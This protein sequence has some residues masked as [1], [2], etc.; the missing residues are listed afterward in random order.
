MKQT[1]IVGFNETT[2]I[3]MS[4]GILLKSFFDDCFISSGLWPPRSLDLS[5][6][7]YDYFLRGYLKNQEYSP[8]PATFEDL[9]RNIVHEI[10]RVPFSMMQRVIN[11][12][13]K[14]AQ[15]CIQGV[16]GQ[17]EHL[18]QYFLQYIFT[19]VLLFF[20]LNFL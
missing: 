16:G 10:D 8:A 20:S 1:A 12:A 3:S 2:R 5:P 13:I 9:K 11:N 6:L 4:Q 18:L 19:I 14:R 7:D 15:T 17:F